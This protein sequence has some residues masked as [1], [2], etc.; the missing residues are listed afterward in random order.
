MPASIA[1]NDTAA[2]FGNSPQKTG[3]PLDHAK[4]FSGKGLEFDGVSDHLS[5]SSDVSNAVFGDYLKTFACWVNFDD[6]TE[7]VIAA[8]WLSSQCIGLKDNQLAACA[9]NSSDDISTV[10][11]LRANQW[12]RIVV[13]SNVDVTDASAV[14]AAYADGFSHFDF[15]INGQLQAKE[16]ANFYRGAGDMLLGARYYSLS[17][18]HI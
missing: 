9:I 10:A 7:Q 5:V 15:Y 2:R 12:Y 13:V 18:I 16:A 3:E 6:L 8:G 1:P 4:L 17:L 11:T 14:T